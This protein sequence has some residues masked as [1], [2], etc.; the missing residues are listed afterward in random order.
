MPAYTGA[1][2]QQQQALSAKYMQCQEGIVTVR[3]YRE[4]R[5][6]TASSSSSETTK[7]EDT[8]T[9]VLLLLLLLYS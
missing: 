2:Q 7:I 6:D 5:L 9:A 8:T 4:K 3:Y 1:T